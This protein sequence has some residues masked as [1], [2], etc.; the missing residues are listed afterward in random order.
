[1]AKKFKCSKCTRRF[2]M[3]AHLARHMASHG[4]KSKRTRSNGKSGRGPGRPRGSRNVVRSTVAPIGISNGIEKLIREMDAYRDQL[5]MQRDT[6]D[7]E[8]QSVDTAMDAVSGSIGISVGIRRPGRPSSASTSRRISAALTRARRRDKVVG[9]LHS[10]GKRGRGR[11]T[12][13]TSRNTG[14][15]LKL[16]IVKVIRRSSK[17][18]SPKQIAAAVQGT[19]YRSFASDLTKLVSNTLPEIDSVRKVGRGQYQA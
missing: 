9:T 11:P 16:A 14:G 5:I 2:S 3:A 13:S 10:G 6:S 18:M 17:P 15:S 7:A 12:G 4:V 19:G 1:M 8:I